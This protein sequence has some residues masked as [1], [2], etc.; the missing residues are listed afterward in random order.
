MNKEECIIRSQG[1]PR[2]NHICAANAKSFDIRHNNVVCGRKWS[3][4]KNEKKRFPMKTIDSIDLI[5]IRGKSNKINK[6]WTNYQNQFIFFGNSNLVSKIYGMIANIWVLK[7]TIDQKIIFLSEKG[8]SSLE[9]A[10]MKSLFC[11]RTKH[12]KQ[13]SWSENRKKTKQTNKKN[14]Y[15]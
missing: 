2:Y 15:W 9:R 8:A 10:S 3:R 14:S 4:E 5:R 11:Y 13:S 12:W 6:I 7:E 1:C